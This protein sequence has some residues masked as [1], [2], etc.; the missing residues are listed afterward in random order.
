MMRK[1]HL[2]QKVSFYVSGAVE[3]A[4]VSAM[5]DYIEANDYSWISVDEWCGVSG[6]RL[7]KPNFYSNVNLVTKE[8]TSLVEL[9]CPEERLYVEGC[10]IKFE[11]DADDKI[12]LNSIEVN[13]CDN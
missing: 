6:E 8:A 5:N 4:F 2:D 12:D 3:E 13:Y 9:H 7:L 10:E 1:L 11:V